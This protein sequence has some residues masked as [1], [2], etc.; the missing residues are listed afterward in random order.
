M[1]DGAVAQFVAGSVIAERGATDRL[2]QAFQAL[3]PDTDRQRQLL[4]LAEDEVAASELGRGASVRRTCGSKV[5]SMLTSYS[6]ENFVSDEYAR[7]LSGARDARRGRRAAAATIRPNASPRGSTRSATARCAGSITSC[8]STCCASKK[9]RCAGA[10]SRETVVGHAEDLVRVGY[11]DQALAARRR[12]RRSKAAG[13]AR[14]SRTRR[15]ACSSGS[16]AAR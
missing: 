6:D 13:A 8:C 10:T 4:A 1:S 7:E 12:G 5:E 2:A 3:V 14:R 11:F 16:A 9:T 15:G